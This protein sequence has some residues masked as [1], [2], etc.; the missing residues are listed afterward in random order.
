MNSVT[1]KTALGFVRGEAGHLVYE[2]ESDEPSD[3]CLVYRQTVH[4]MCD[5][6]IH[7][8]PTYT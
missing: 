2:P 6:L 1:G 8:M 4:N 3:E 5:G 7:V